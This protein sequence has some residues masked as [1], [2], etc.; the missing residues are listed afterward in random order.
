MRL[1]LAHLRAARGSLL[2]IATIVA[3]L[4]GSAV[5]APL[6][7][8]GMLDAS[9]R[10]RL[11]TLSPT[12]RDLSVSGAFR[13]D[14]T[15]FGPTA[16][17]EA[18][19]WATWESAL[20]GIRDEAGAPVRSSFGEAQYITRWGMPG[21][22]TGTTYVVLDPH[23]AQRIRIVDGRLPDPPA[24]PEA[25]VEALSGLWDPRTGIVNGET[26]EL[27]ATEIVLSVESARD[28][29]WEI[30]ETR[31]VGAEA[32]WWTDVPL[33]LVGTFAPTDDDDPYWLRTSGMSGADVGFNPDGV[34]YERVSAFAAPEAL[35]TLP[36]ANPAGVQTDIWMP[37]DP[38]TV[39]AGGAAELLASLRA[40]VA[41]SHPLERDGF[42]FAD[43]TFHTG[44][45]DALDRANVQNTSLIAVLAMLLSGP[46]GVALA[47]LVLACRMLWE[48]RRAAFA[49]LAARG[50]SGGQLRGLLTVDGLIVG[51]VPAVIGAGAGLLLSGVVAPG[52][53][54]ILGLFVAPTVLALLPAAVGAVMASRGGKIG[55][56][57][58][59]GSS[60]WRGVVE[61]VIVVLAVLSTALLVVRGVAATTDGID[62]LAVAAPVLLALAACVL[63]L[64]VYPVALR[65]LLRRARK[66]PG[67]IGM[68]GAAR[69]LRDPAVGVAPVLAL[70]VGVSFAVAGGVIL[71]IVQE[72]AQ[73]TARVETGAD[74]Q[75]QALRFPAD[76]AAQI[77]AVDGVAATAAV[78]VVLA[79]E[80]SIDNVRSRVSLYVA[81]RA[82]LDAAQAG[83]PATVPDA[84][85]LG[86]GSGAP[87][88]LTSDTVAARGL[89]DSDAIE[90]GM[91]GA[92]FV[93][94]VPG[95]AAFA[96]GP[97]W[98]LV[99]RSF[100]PQI[101]ER[102]ATTASVLVSLEPDADP[103][104]VSAAIA[105]IVG[106]G[107]RITTAVDVRASIDADP[108]VSG[109]R[110]VL[111]SGIAAS[112]VLS[113]VAVVVTLVLGARA[114][115]RILALLQTLGAPPSAGGRLLAW[116]LAPVS[117]AALV[118]GAAFGAALPVLLSTVIDLR[119]FT[120]G[121]VPPAYVVDPVILA[122]T[123]GGF[124]AVTVLVTS[125][126]LA[127]ARRARAAAVLR[128]V[129]DS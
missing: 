31:N 24:D 12:V 122:V 113:A 29:E 38:S 71:S 69:A 25:W 34:P 120:S 129:E 50:A 127:V 41:K 51:I 119:A 1:F 20:A 109:L 17:A 108:A 97:T 66:G 78:Q 32:Q 65:M 58:G 40:Y 45:I 79:T 37:A 52:V 36:S 73:Q 75:V 61:L 3:V 86:D 80:L 93:G 33:T 68:L 53:P 8:T 87:R 18:S 98:A 35:A 92:E 43:L 9:T 5:L 63:T 57:D 49:L 105:E 82:E 47:V 117:V 54:P 114:R 14:F 95:V 101:T 16:E 27:A 91:A 115:R 26:V 46:L 6:A 77:A 28:V 74:L 55:R 11:E 30:G 110:L 19:T 116:E 7:V 48:T 81:D 99:D 85:D 84:I 128:T 83:Y 22:F 106:S 90:I 125:V 42:R 72:G 107:A 88:L 67:F 96:S 2:T 56:A 111:L 62:P 89:D 94:S 23:F 124:I 13:P 15:L 118:V 121:A 21:E 126:A 4:A 64:R 100:L 44:S 123:V 10:Y 60:A 112:A 70:V 103:D 76:A 59:A 104:A 39:T 102:P